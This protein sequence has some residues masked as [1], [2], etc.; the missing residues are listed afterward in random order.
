M[1]TLIVLSHPTFDT[2]VVNRALVAE[3]KKTPDIFTIHHLES[4]YPTGAIDVPT[5]QALVEAH[6]KLELQFPLYWFNCPPMLKKWLD[7]VLTHNWAYGSQGDKLRGRKVAL[8]VTAGI[9]AQEYAASGKY[10]YQLEEILRPFQMTLTYCQAAY[11]SFFAF[12]GAERANETDDHAYA[13]RVAQS[14]KNYA[15][16]IKNM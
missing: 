6:E 1:K 12:Y 9:D 15:E 4:R 16:F 13:S 3:L 5:E 7:E 14:A 2:S 8:A 10:G 11:K